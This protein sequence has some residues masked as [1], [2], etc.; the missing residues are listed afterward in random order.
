MMKNNY[1]KLALTLGISFVIMLLLTY[2]MIRE[3]GH[4]YF[5]LANTY[6]ALMMVAQMGILMLLIM[7]GMFKNR[8]LNGG[9][10]CR[11]GRG[12]RRRLRVRT[13][14]NVHR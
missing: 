13:G 6:M 5:N 14:R 4:F 10:H 8:R 11:V 12:L 9:A 3:W 2:S 1:V 7:W